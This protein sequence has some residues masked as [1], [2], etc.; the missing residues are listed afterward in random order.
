MNKWAHFVGTL[1]L[2]AIGIST[3]AVQLQASHHPTVAIVAAAAW[4]ILGNLLPPPLGM[5]ARMFKG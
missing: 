2:G 3:P 4:A 1:A 5:L